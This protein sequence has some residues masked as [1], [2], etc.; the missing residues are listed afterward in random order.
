M[1]E[2]WKDLIAIL[3]DRYVL[4]NKCVEKH[5]KTDSKIT[6]LS[7]VQSMIVTKLGFIEKIG[8]AILG[9]LIT[10]MGTSIW[11]LITKK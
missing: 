5:E 4:Q 2:E 8:V 9:V 11:N 6:E 7:L 3:D 10:L 1:M